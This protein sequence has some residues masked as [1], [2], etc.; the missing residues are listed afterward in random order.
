MRPGKGGLP[1]EGYALTHN[2]FVAS[3]GAGQFVD[4]LGRNQPPDRAFNYTCPSSACAD[5]HGYPHAENIP[6]AIKTLDLDS[7]IVFTGGP[8]AKKQAWDNFLADAETKY[9][10]KEIW[11][12]DVANWSLL[13]ARGHTSSAVAHCLAH[14]QQFP[15]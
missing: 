7:T 14:T 9:G 6:I 10:V 5:K 15:S 11:S 13:E 1:I 4:R 12:D 2:V 8:G 3:N